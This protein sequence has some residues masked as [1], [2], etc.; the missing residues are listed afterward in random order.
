MPKSRIRKKDKPAPEPKPANLG[1]SAP[2][3]APL[4]LGLFLFGLIWI[5]V[6]YVSNGDYPIGSL[7]N[8]NLLVGF[9]FITGGFITSTQWR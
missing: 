9:G 6:Y 5:V 7:N 4:M 2:W 3:V 8:Y 1:P